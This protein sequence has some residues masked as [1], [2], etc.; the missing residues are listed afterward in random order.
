MAWSRYLLVLSTL[1][2]SVAYYAVSIRR[3]TLA[4]TYFDFA[5]AVSFNPTVINLVAIRPYIV[6]QCLP[7]PLSISMGIVK[8]VDHQPVGL[9]EKE[10]NTAHPRQSLFQRKMSCLMCNLSSIIHSVLPSIP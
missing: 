1:Q 10:S 5:S 6:T 7:V 2:L 3:S 8:H 9:S 4:S